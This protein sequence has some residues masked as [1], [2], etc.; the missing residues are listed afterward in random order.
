MAVTTIGPGTTL[1]RYELG[2]LIG[3][4]GMAQVFSATDQELGR[5]VA[6]KVLN[7][8]ISKQPEFRARFLREARVMA[9]LSHE[10]IVKVYDCGEDDTW[11]WMAME[12]IEGETLEAKLAR[13]PQPPLTWV[14]EVMRA[15]LSALDHVHAREIIHRDVKPQN[16]LLGKNDE[17]KLVDF[18]LV[19]V[20]DQLNVTRVGIRLGTPR[21][22]SP[23]AARGEAVTYQSDLF[24]AGLLLHELLTGRLPMEEIRDQAAY[25]RLKSGASPHPSRMRP[26]LPEEMDK[27]VVKSLAFKSWDR[28]DNSKK[29]A[30]AL[31]RIKLPSAEP[32]PSTGQIADRKKRDD[33]TVVEKVGA[34]AKD[35][36][37]I[38]EF[39]KAKEDADR[40]AGKKDKKHRKHKHKHKHKRRRWP[41]MLGVLTGGIAAAV[42]AAVLFV[43]DRTIVRPPKPSPTATASAL[44][45]RS[46]TPG[47]SP[48]PSSSLVPGSPL[49]VG[50]PRTELTRARAV[51]AEIS[52][53]PGKGGTS[54]GLQLARDGQ[55]HLENVLDVLKEKTLEAGLGADG[56]REFLHLLDRFDETI[57]RVR[58][59]E[60][61]FKGM[62]VE[63]AVLGRVIDI[64]QRIAG[65]N[66][67]LAML[68]RIAAAEA[69]DPQFWELASRCA[70]RVGLMV[71]AVLARYRWQETVAQPRRAARGPAL[72]VGELKLLSRADQV[73]LTIQLPKAAGVA[74]ISSARAP[75]SAVWDRLA[76]ALAGARP[77]PATVAPVAP[78]SPS[79]KSPG[80][81][82]GEGTDELN[83]LE[84]M[85][86]EI[87][88]KKPVVPQGPVVLRTAIRPRQ[89]R[90]A[91]PA[92]QAIEAAI[93]ELRAVPAATAAKDGRLAKAITALIE[94]MAR[95][96]ACA[97]VD[98]AAIEFY[99]PGQRALY[100]ALADLHAYLGALPRAEGALRN[101]LLEYVEALRQMGE[102]PLDDAGYWVLYGQAGLLVGQLSVAEDAFLHA[103]AAPLGHP[104]GR[105]PAD[106]LTGP[107]FAGLARTVWARFEANGD[108]GPTKPSLLDHTLIDL[109]LFRLHVIELGLSGLPAPVLAGW[110]WTPA[111]AKL[112]AT[113]AARARA[114]L[115]RRGEIAP[116]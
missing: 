44:A 71:P 48:S 27:V 12:L 24:S 67:R 25:D 83:D 64:R 34:G 31:A 113:H 99:E 102:I 95:L 45:V 23:E 55:K 16:V 49:P 38:E 11:A 80:K 85:E 111:D 58:D 77:V 115:V 1:G 100:Q 89:H 52:R 15:V 87:I 54:V 110:S 21:Y 35:V 107:A 46:P 2:P 42:V 106:V 47:P 79:P 41:V 8:Q 51:W 66:P 10:N 40:E 105:G 65:K 6:L 76:G 50:D 39:D 28:F 20:E 90:M 108:P 4:G 30:D 74:P 93:R 60:S 53:P 73:M 98:E 75:W 101:Q 36:T 88:D 59:A 29:F 104:E 32:P 62:L 109:D 9:G 19:K 18:G 84:R 103:L 37:V 63:E 7:F 13:E 68:D 56:R 112:L 78:A 26:G 14:V 94:Q 97:K 114:I 72:L 69:S 70:F 33:R 57:T 96:R 92:W 5:P 91:A 82:L 116:K 17:I 22:M 3:K 61:L 81:E 43:Y 86:D